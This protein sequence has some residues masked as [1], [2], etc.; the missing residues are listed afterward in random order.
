MKF[1]H[2]NLSPA[3]RPGV[4]DDLHDTLRLAQLANVSVPDFALHVVALDRPHD[5]ALLPEHQLVT[6]QSTMPGPLAA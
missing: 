1:L 4:M 5:E 3:I 2:D 6:P